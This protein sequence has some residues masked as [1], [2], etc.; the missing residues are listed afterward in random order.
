[1]VAFLLTPP[2]S[3]QCPLCPDVAPPLSPP[4]PS[5]AAADFFQMKRVAAGARMQPLDLARYECLPPPKELLKD[6]SA[7]RQALS[8]AKAQLAH[9]HNRVDNLELLQQFGSQ[10]FLQQNSALAT[11]A[12][13]LG[14]QAAAAAS[15]AEQANLKRKVAQEEAAPR[16]RQLAHSYATKLDDNQQLSYAVA[17][18][19]ADV[20]RLRAAA[21]QQG[22]V[23]TLAQEAEE[24]RAADPSQARGSGFGGGT[25][26]SE[27]NLF[28][29]G[30][31]TGMED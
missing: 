9:Q 21:E 12:N 6:P 28:A 16:L 3:H 14:A 30:E 20:E 25:L 29:G 26:A 10:A 31:V 18:L 13:G 23:K 22:L 11:L 7:W 17:L 27:V 15:G 2:V 19:G 5:A 1:M 24:A 8:N 4:Q